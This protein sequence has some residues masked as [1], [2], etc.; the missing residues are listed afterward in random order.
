MH[1]CS[2][3]PGSCL[4]RN[5]AAVAGHYILLEDC[6]FSRDQDKEVGN[7][8]TDSGVCWWR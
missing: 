4:M 2:V 8:V 6:V 1:D 5:F 7:S 3:A